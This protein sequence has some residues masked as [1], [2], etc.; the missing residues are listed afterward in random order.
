MSAEGQGAGARIAGEEAAGE[1][2]APLLDREAPAPRV[3]RARRREAEP[4]R[5][6]SVRWLLT[7]VEVSRLD[8]IDAD[9][10]TQR[11]VLCFQDS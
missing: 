8:C 10:R 6:R 11:A 9:F 1:G 4:R 7:K 3:L 5:G 2:G